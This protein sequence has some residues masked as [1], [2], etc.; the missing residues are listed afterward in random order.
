MPKLLR[1]IIET[2]KNTS[3]KRL[4]VPALILLF[5]IL[6]YF[7]IVKDLPSPTTLSSPDIPQ[8][9]QIVDRDGELLY[10]IYSQKNRA[11]I[12]LSQIPKYVRDATIAIE[13][14]DFYRHGPIDPRGIARALYQTFFKR[15]L[16]GGSTI[17]QQLVKTAL[18][19]PERTIPRKIKEFLLAAVVEQLYTKDQILELY[20]NHVPYGGTAYGIE[21][22][23]QTY[24]NKQAKELTLAEAALL[25]GL[26]TAP[27]YYSPLVY[28]QRAI[29]RQKGVLLKMEEQRII[30]NDERQYAEKEILKFT[31]IT[32]QIRAPHFVFYV[33]ELLEARYGQKLVEQ[34][35]LKVT[36]SLELTLQDFAQQ[37]VASE[38]AK[39][40]NVNVGNGAALIT[41]PKTGEIL[42]MVGS[43]DY[44][45]PEI[46]GNVNVTTSAR[47][48][49]S[50]IKPINYAVGL[51]KGYTAATPFVDQKTCFPNPGKEPYCPVN[52]DDKFH[53]AV[54]MRYALGNSYNIPAVKMLKLA[55]VTDM[56]A[57]ATAMGITTF[58]DPS[59]YGL[60]LTL[61][62]GE[63]TMVELAQAYGVFANQGYRID[64]HPILKVVDR[65]GKVLEEY[66]AP[67]SPIFGKK[68]LPENVAFII[69]HILT[70]NGA[71]SAAFGE[72]SYLVVPEQQVAV[73]TGTTDD[74]R[75]NW[76]IGWTPSILTA[77]WVGN[78][79]NSPMDPSLTSGVTGAAPIW[80]KIMRFVLRDRKPEFPKI[81]SS[82]VGAQVCS[83]SGKLPQ[84]EGDPNRCPTRFEYFVLGTVPRETDNS[85]QKVFIDKTTNDLAKPGQ[86]DNIEEKEEMAVTDPLGDRYCLSCPHPEQK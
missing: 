27:T 36:T 50:A 49:G 72:S 68:I 18:L 10:A 12:P 4:F 6:F 45:D 69:S 46:D 3:K 13:D 20:L 1:N 41:N 55:G 83:T 62:G 63:I 30:T 38:V 8:S 14:K 77:V 34:G 56:I 81:P 53:G 23:A 28:P 7:F 79:D 61:G 44:F 57:T 2:L 26:P 67:T 60:S 80:N 17:T 42:A 84:A 39:L 40:K 5:I 65:K 78:N 64:L 82:V 52:Y 35:G 51:S 16:Q 86:T 58:K 19:T 15:Q 85:K 73:K 33:K 47:Q 29:T 31:K 43:R 24:F 70:D 74:K 22:A 71:R 59:R 9:S 25:A 66:K 37:S 11:A 48:P 54:Q 76:T 32:S 21:A 75:D